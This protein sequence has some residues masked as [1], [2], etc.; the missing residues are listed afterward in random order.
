[1]I[2]TDWFAGSVKPVRKGVYEREYIYGKAKI[3]YFCYWDGKY[4]FLASSTVDGAE[5]N[6]QF[7][8][9]APNQSLRWRGVLK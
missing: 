4:W 1:M 2:L 3:P 8:N 9:V 5:K 6:F 7:G